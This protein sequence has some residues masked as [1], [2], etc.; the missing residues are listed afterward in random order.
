MLGQPK[1]ETAQSKKVQFSTNYTNCTSFVFVSG[2]VVL[3]SLLLK[4]SVFYAC[5]Y[6]TVMDSQSPLFKYCNI[7]YLDKFV[8]N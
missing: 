3:L 2:I 5:L 6:D 1:S 4:C 7:Y 8:L